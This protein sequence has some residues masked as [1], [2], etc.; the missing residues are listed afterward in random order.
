MSEK[1]G[2][3]ART[4]RRADR[5]GRY[6][7]DGAVFISFRVQKVTEQQCGNMCSQGK[8]VAW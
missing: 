7:E 8:E 2:Q 4:F 3:A 5:A 6:S 1:V